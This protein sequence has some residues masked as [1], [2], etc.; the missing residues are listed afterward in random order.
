ME[1]EGFCWVK[2]AGVWGW[3]W[4]LL[5]GSKLHVHIAR[6]TA[7]KQALRKTEGRLTTRAQESCQGGQDD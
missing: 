2:V 3:G 4:F 7:N 1:V 5:Q 6:Q